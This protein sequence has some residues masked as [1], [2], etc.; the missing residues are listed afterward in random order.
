MTAAKL[1]E[2]QQFA[3]KWLARQGGTGI[4]DKHARVVA[5]GEVFPKGP[6][7]TWLRLLAAGLIGYAGPGR[8]GLSMGG[9]EAA[10]RLEASQ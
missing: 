6:S 2:A 5:A 10:E 1:S 9:W 8:I 4:I 3:L 7:P